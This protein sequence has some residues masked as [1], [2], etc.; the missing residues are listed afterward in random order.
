MSGVSLHSILVEPAQSFGEVPSQS[1]RKQE[2][3]D[4]EGKW[5]KQGNR[6]LQKGQSTVSKKSN[7]NIISNPNQ[8]E[9]ISNKATNNSVPNND[10]VDEEQLNE[11]QY[12]KKWI[13]SIQMNVKGIAPFHIIAFALRLH[14]ISVG[15]T[16]H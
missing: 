8:P 6:V 3:N 1:Q 16:P 11:M 2:E 7:V 5:I 15:D 14:Q 12:Y 9:D 13:E 4:Q 10:M